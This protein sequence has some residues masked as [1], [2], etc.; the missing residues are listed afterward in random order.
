MAAPIIQHVTV[1]ADDSA[2]AREALGFA[3]DLAKKYGAELTVLTVAPLVPLYVASSEPWVPATSPDTP[4]YR[5]LLDR[6]VQEARTAG[7]L[8]KGICVE[9]V[10][11]DEILAQVEANPPDLLVIGS[12]GLS[13]GKRLLLGS[14]STAILHAVK[15]PVLVVHPRSTT[16]S[17]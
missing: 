10:A 13:R 2:I 1:A 15:C 17:S 4:Y 16:P 7:V 6:A 14:V 11:V 3:I 12:R 9:G 8:A 5:Q